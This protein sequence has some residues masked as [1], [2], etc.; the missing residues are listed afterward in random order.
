MTAM[1]ALVLDRMNEE[2]APVARANFA[3]RHDG[4][5]YE[6]AGGFTHDNFDELLKWAGERKASDITF[7]TNE[8][9][10]SEI[11]AQIVPITKRALSKN[12]MEDLAR[13]VYAA[14]GPGMVL[15]G[16]DL[17]PS[18]EVRIGGQLF[19]Y[20]V[21][22]TGIRVPQSTGIQI[23]VRTLPQRPIPL[24]QLNVE[25]G[26]LANKRPNQGLFLVTGPTGSGKSTL[27][28]SILGDIVSTPN[29]NEKVLEYA[30]PIEYVYDGIV[31]PS[32]SVAQTE[33]PKHLRPHDGGG[34]DSQESLWGYAIRN[35]LRRKP[36]IISI[37]EARDKATIAGCV[38]A[39]LTGHLVYSTTHVIGVAETLRR[40]IQ[41]FGGDEKRAMG[42][43]IMQSM[44]VIVTQLLFPR[45][46]GGKVACREFAIF[47]ASTR[48]QFLTKNPDDWPAFARK[49]MVSGR[50]MSRTMS[51][52]AY[53]AYRAGALS[54]EDWMRIVSAEREST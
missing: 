29:A 38:E 6:F 21:N 31:D 9:V 41:P 51:E 11:G 52:S 8:P 2:P 18:H 19:R 47:D 17:D 13:H 4:S 27:M 12:E 42:Y 10:K 54:R 30:S 22:V 23:T 49:L 46:G 26:I 1:D 37:G 39:A 28:S 3:T 45:V 35:A 25:E 14:H 44:R 20:R 40:L 24:A 48:N 5:F 32:C 36:T 15:A 50:I 34:Q 33:V 43:D 16:Y 7:Q 53:Q